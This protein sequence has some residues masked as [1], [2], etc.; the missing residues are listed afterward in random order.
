MKI[1]KRTPEDFEYKMELLKEAVLLNMELEETNE[2]I[3]FILDS[4]DE[5]Q[6]QLFIEL[7]INLKVVQGLN[8]EEII[9]KINIKKC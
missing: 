6:K 7:L 5:V 3:D 1:P 9:K 8:I 4:L 2:K